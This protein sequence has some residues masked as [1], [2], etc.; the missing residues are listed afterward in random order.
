MVRSRRY[1]E[2]YIKWKFKTHKTELMVLFECFFSPSSLLCFFS[3]ISFCFVILF[4]IKNMRAYFVLY[5]YQICTHTTADNWNS[6]HLF[7]CCPHGLENTSMRIERCGGHV[8]ACVSVG[9][10]CMYV[11]RPFSSTK[12]ILA[13]KFD[14]YMSYL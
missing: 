4:T 3:F 7:L 8:C 2:Q 5:I 13:Y 10:M 12:K 14:F 6:F 9:V 11:P 1:Y